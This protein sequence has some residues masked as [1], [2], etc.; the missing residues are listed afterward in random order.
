V[1]RIKIAV[2]K[3]A[4]IPGALALAF[5]GCGKLE[6]VNTAQPV[7]AKDP[8]EDIH[9]VG[10]NTDMTSSGLVEQKIRG[11]KALFSQSENKLIVD[12]MSLAT[13]SDAHT[14]RGITKADTGTFYLA[15]VGADKRGK[16]DMVFNGHV[17]YR[18]PLATD[19]TSDT[20]QLKTKTI[21]WDNGLQKFL[22][23]GPYEMTLFPPAKN[24]IRQVGEGFE[25]SRDLTRFVVRGGVVSSGVTSDPLVMRRTLQNEFNQSVS[26]VNREVQKAINITPMRPIDLPGK[27]STSKN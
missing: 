17:T 11:K 16:S 26:M 13:M 6:F 3:N 22:C 27:D 8:R 15:P 21:I 14:T 24:A 19:P 23:P 9:L 12:N 10:V 18:A 5:T 25:A 1:N 7:P 2:I 4:L 20:L